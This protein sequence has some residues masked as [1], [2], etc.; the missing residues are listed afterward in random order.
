MEYIVLKNTDIKVSR[1]CLGGC[2]MG[3]YG[4]GGSKSQN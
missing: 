4:W 1:L 3:Q 2:P